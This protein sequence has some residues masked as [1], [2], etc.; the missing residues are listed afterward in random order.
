MRTRPSARANNVTDSE[1]IMALKFQPWNVRHTEHFLLDLTR[2]GG[3]NRHDTAYA[4]GHLLLVIICTYFHI[5]VRRIK[6]WTFFLN[7]PITQNSRLPSPFFTEPPS[8]TSLNF[9]RNDNLA[10]TKAF[11]LPATLGVSL[12]LSSQAFSTCHLL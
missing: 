5:H 11:F 2:Q 1:R 7:W 9:F 8:P 6:N 3:I 4:H 12:V 10:W